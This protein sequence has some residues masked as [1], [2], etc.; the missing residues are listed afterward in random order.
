ME[1]DLEIQKIFDENKVEDLKDFIKQRSCL[2][3][4]TQYLTYLFYL[5]QASGVFLVSIGKSY[6]NDLLVWVGVGCNSFASFI[7]IVINSN[8]KIN[9]G[10]LSNIRSI[11]SGNYVDE[12]VVDGMTERKSTG[13]PETPKFKKSIT[14]V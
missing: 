10:L 1:V 9:A 4:T 13:V 7:Y 6:G 5:L 8:A 2:N 3:F 11:K 12:G 14:E